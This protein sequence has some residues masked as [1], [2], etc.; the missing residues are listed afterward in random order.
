MLLGWALLRLT[1]RACGH[2]GLFDPCNMIQ[3]FGAGAA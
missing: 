1:C 3:F 2:T